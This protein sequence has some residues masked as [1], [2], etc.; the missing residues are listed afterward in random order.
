MQIFPEDLSEQFP[1]LDEAGLLDKAMELYRAEPSAS[2]YET[3]GQYLLTF[4]HRYTR[5]NVEKGFFPWRDFNQDLAQDSMLK[6]LEGLNT[7]DSAR[8]EPF[9]KWVITIINNTVRN[10]YDHQNYESEALVPLD[11][12]KHDQPSDAISRALPEKLKAVL[13]SLSL[14][15]QRLFRLMWEG[16]S[17]KEASDQLGIKLSAAKMRWSRL[18]PKMR[19][20]REVVYTVDGERVLEMKREKDGTYK[21]NIGGKTVF[22]TP[23]YLVIKE[24]PLP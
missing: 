4:T 12:I 1:D 20:F 13:A 8:P 6:V 7:W 9:N 23:D 24:I 19:Q 11:L 3:L 21:C 10:A 14:E 18:V 17:L 5:A 22:A 16:F 2:N 15:D